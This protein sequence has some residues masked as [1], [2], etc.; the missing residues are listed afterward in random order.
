MFPFL[1]IHSQQKL[2]LGKFKKLQCQ[3]NQ[4]V[5]RTDE[6]LKQHQRLPS[7]M[8][9][10]TGESIITSN[11]F[12]YTHPIPLPTHRYAS[13]ATSDV[14]GGGG[15]MLRATGHTLQTLG[16]AAGALR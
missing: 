1:L 5:F 14:A 10:P 2:T 7:T 9:M 3:L 4:P 11:S 16:G 6:S 8:M 15:G 12:S 13:I